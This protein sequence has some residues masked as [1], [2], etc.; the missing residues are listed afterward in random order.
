MATIK[1]VAVMAGVS[2]ATVS[3]VLNDSHR[4]RPET[5]QRVLWAVKELGYLPNMAARSLVVGHSSIV[6]MIVADID[7]P[8]F[9]EIAKTFQEEAHLSGLETIV[10]NTNSDRL[11][12][13]SMVERLLSLQVRGAAFMTTQADG[14]IKEFV[15]KKGMPAVYLGFGSADR[16]SGN[17]AIEQ[18]LGILEAVDHLASLGHK[19]VGF[20]SGPADGLFAQRRKAAFVEGALAAGFETRVVESDLTVQGGYFSCS[21]LLYGFEA[22][23]LMAGND[24]MAIGAMHYLYEHQIPVPAAMSVVGFEDIT[25]AQFTQPPLTTVAVPRGEIGRLAFQSLSRLLDKSS[26]GGCDY[27]VK[28]S[29][30]LRQTTAAPPVGQ[31]T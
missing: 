15:S 26:Q 7:N 23:A 3:Y 20:I 30:V 18:R 25:F 6:G 27:E 13:R 5:G 4:V 16:N 10:L 21:K 2:P 8:F 31:D 1:E 29:L 19:R 11:R 28:A 17:V 9:A 12:T 14:P 24:L 22:T